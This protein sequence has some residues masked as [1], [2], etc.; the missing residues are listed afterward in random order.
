MNRSART[1]QRS[2][3]L[4]GVLALAFAAVA[5]QGGIGIGTVLV[6]GDEARITVTQTG[7]DDAELR[8]TVTARMASGTVHTVSTVVLAAPDSPTDIVLQFPEPIRDII[9]LGVIYED[10]NPF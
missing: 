8:A 2:L 4:A 3:I 10:T 5:A 7:S 1:P 6:A 9:D